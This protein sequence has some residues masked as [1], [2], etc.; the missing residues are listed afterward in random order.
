MALLSRCSGK[1]FLLLTGKERLVYEPGLL[2][3]ARRFA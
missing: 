1:H 3:D 2:D